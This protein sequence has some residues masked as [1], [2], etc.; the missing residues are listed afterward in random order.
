MAMFSGLKQALTAEA[1]P[2]TFI[3]AAIFKRLHEK[4]QASVRGYMAQLLQWASPLA[5][6]ARHQPNRQKTQAS[7]DPT[8]GGGANLNRA[9]S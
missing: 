9:E 3:T 1:N 2:A 7:G 8:F 4:I 6:P 5:H